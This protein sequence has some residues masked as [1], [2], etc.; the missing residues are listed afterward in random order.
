MAIKKNYPVQAVT[1]EAVSS[2]VF[3]QDD[4]VLRHADRTRRA[5]GLTPGQRKKI[6]ADRARKKASYDLPEWL[7]KA[8][9]ELAQEQSVPVSSV[10]GA[11]LIQAMRAGVDLERWPRRPSHSPFYDSVLVLPESEEK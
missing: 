1:D 11:M 2:A 9:R 5:K 4:P 7:I 3:G 8:V 10:A 6:E